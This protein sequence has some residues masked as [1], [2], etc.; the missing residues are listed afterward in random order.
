VAGHGARCA[1]S[2]GT[3]EGAEVALG[4]PVVGRRAMGWRSRRAMRRRSRRAMGVAGQ[5]A[6]RW[7]SR[8]RSSAPLALGGEAKAVAVAAYLGGGGGGWA[9]TM[10][11][12]ARVANVGATACA[13]G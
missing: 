12:R 11:G 10:R 1:G 8:W 3:A 9:G 5:R 6:P 4:M 2:E 7:R 13:S